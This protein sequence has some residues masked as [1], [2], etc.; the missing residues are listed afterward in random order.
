MDFSAKILRYFHALH[1]SLSVVFLDQKNNLRM[2]LALSTKFLAQLSKAEVSQPQHYSHF[3]PAN[4]L[5]GEGCPVNCRVFGSIAGL[6]PDASNS[7][8]VTP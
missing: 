7:P 8:P 5:F 3:E 1:Q 6:P 4:S 2:I